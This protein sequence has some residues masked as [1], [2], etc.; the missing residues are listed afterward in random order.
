MWTVII[1]KLPKLWNV[2]RCVRCEASKCSAGRAQ[3][4]IYCD[5]YSTGEHFPIQIIRLSII[6]VKVTS[7]REHNRWAQVYIDRCGRGVVR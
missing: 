6:V 3:R 7:N 4:K 2:A 5:V 1:L